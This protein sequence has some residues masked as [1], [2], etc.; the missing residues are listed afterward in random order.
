MRATAHDPAPD[1]DA[2]PA[3]L[4][5]HGLLGGWTIRCT[6]SGGG[7]IGAMYG[8]PFATYGMVRAQQL[9]AI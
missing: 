4:S 9:M 8:R 5:Q 6:V 2:T 1:S 7:Y 3:G